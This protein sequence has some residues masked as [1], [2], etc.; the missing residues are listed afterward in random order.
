MVP[1]FACH[2]FF[3]FNFLLKAVLPQ[4][5]GHLLGECRPSQVPGAPPGD[6]V[7]RAMGELRLQAPAH[8]LLSHLTLLAGAKFK[9]KIIKH[10]KMVT[11]EH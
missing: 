4:A 7:N 10:F 2:V 9:D 6:K 5:Q 3:F 1:I 11:T 8:V